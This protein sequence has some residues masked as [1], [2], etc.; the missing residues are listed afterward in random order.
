MCSLLLIGQATARHEIHLKPVAEK[1][2]AHIFKRY[3]LKHK[4]V[5]KLLQICYK[6]INFFENRHR[7][8][9]VVT[10]VVLAGT[11]IVVV[12]VTVNILPFITVIIH[13]Y[14]IVNS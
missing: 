6:K 12:I 4:F 2:Y 14:F 13:I 7:S 8:I 9:V 3:K 5:Y 11:G 10:V 1:E